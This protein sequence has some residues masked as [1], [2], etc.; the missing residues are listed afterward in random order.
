VLPTDTLEAIK[1]TFDP[2][3]GTNTIEMKFISNKNEMNDEK[4][5]LVWLLFSKLYLRKSKPAS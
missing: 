2:A 1:L 3:T 5:T 4:A